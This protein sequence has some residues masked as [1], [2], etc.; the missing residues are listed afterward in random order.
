MPFVFSVYE[1]IVMKLT[2]VAIIKQITQVRD[3]CIPKPWKNDQSRATGYF[4]VLIALL[5][6][7]LHMQKKKKK[8]TCCEGNYAL[9][10]SC[11]NDFWQNWSNALGKETESPCPC[12][13]TRRDQYCQDDYIISKESLDKILHTGYPCDLCIKDQRFYMED[14][15]KSVN[16]L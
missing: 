15:C 8:K 4:Y 14:P 13:N 16:H 6:Q 12:S 3:I 11:W 1:T 5:D 2:E 7:I 10:T 9:I